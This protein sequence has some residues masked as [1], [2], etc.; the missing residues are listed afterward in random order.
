MKTIINFPFRDRITINEL[1]WEWKFQ[2]QNTL[3][4]QKSL[5][6][7]WIITKLVVKLVDKRAVHFPFLVRFI[8]GRPKADVG[9]MASK[10][11][12]TKLQN[13]ENSKIRKFEN[14]VDVR[15]YFE[16]CLSNWNALNFESCFLYFH[17]ELKYSGIGKH[18]WE[19]K[20]CA[21][22]GQCGL[23]LES[24]IW[25]VLCKISFEYSSDISLIIGA[26]FGIKDVDL[27][28]RQVQDW[29]SF[30]HLFFRKL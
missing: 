16:K 24:H 29:F 27:L 25:W 4:N 18:E 17:D 19:R 11:R 20:H 2:L 6:L 5:E 9:R 10:K 8:Y 15:R 22:W 3:I 30:C 21:I 23:Y 1:Y 14:S 7:R 13:S 28:V 12:S 26:E